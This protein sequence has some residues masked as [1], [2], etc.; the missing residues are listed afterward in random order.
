MPEIA[1][2]SLEWALIV[3]LLATVAGGLGALR[4]DRRLAELCRRAVYVVAALLTLAEAIL[5]VA[6]LR[7][8]F[9][10]DYVASYSSRDLPTL[11]Q[12]TVLWAGQSGSLLF[13]TWLQAVLVVVLVWANGRRRVSGDRALVVALATM[14]GIQ[15]V[16]LAI[17]AG[18]TSP[19]TLLAQVPAD[20]HGLNPLLQNPWMAF[21]P[22][23]LFV[24]YVGMAVPFAL[25]IG[26][27]ATR[28]A[29]A[30]WLPQCRR[31]ALVAW[32]FLT[33]GIVVGGLW[34]YL[35]L[36]WGGYWAWDPVE[37]ASLIPWLTGTA[38]LHT[39]IL[40]ERQGR[41]PRLNLALLGVTFALTLFGTFLTR[42]GVL[43]SLHAFA[44]NLK[45]GA[46][47]LLLIG[48]S[49]ALLA[50]L[51]AK[52]WRQWPGGPWLDSFAS[53][54]MAF[55]LGILLLLLLAA[56][57]LLGTTLPLYGKLIGLGEATVGVPFYN[58]ATGPLFLL[59]LAA[60]G[61]APLL[62]WRGAGEGHLPWRRL[63]WPLAAGVLV[64]LALR[65]AGITA[66]QALAGYAITTFIVGV[67]VVR[68]AR[69]VQAGR[70]AGR[71]AWW[72]LVPAT[73]WQRRRRYGAL[74]AHVGV[75]ILATGVIASSF[76]QVERSSALALQERLT[77]GGYELRYTDLDY[78]QRANAEVV[79][80]RLELWRSGRLVGELRPERRLYSRSQQVMT[81]ASRHGT[82]L[83][84]V[85]V[86]LASVTQDNRVVLKAYVNP[87]VQWIW[88]SCFV[89]VA[90][91]ALALVPGRSP[92]ELAATS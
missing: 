56:T 21:H 34:A 27:L 31:W 7:H 47:F 68:L 92:A 61:I 30:A 85:Y 88:G 78:Y 6:I 73:V 80:A 44:P 90:G 39:M 48:A 25:A 76:H 55:V 23:V 72:R 1:K 43:A 63:A 65:L 69:D 60:M 24:G 36:G 33:V 62:P 91:V 20:G 38:M 2:F 26:A 74:L 29:D 41:L 19:F 52:R 49:L 83:N 4:G 54:E 84:E 66:G 89:L 46:L 50:V 42:S 71:G 35:E 82:W 75:A 77:I 58:R 67:A 81:E 79:G 15:A 12:V 86:I 37:N 53:R 16:L 28:Q 57:V 10:L 3:A 13:W 51:L 18:I 17:L 5:L 40:H 32:C 59:L 45:L 14:H 22:P 64:A 9:R 70:A 87:L 11:Y 8:D